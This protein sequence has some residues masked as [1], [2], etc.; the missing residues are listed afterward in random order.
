MSISC[1]ACCAVCVTP[2]ICTST[3]AARINSRSRETAV[4][5]VIRRGDRGRLVLMPASGGALP[6]RL[7]RDSRLRVG[8]SVH[9]RL[10]EGQAVIAAVT[11]RSQEP[12]IGR[13]IAGTRGWY[14]VAEGDFRGR[15]YLEPN[16]HGAATT[17]TPLRSTVTGEESFGLIGRVVDV[18]APR[19]DL[20][21]ASITLLRAHGVPVEWPAG[22][23]RRSAR[24]AGPCRPEACTATAK[25]S[26][27][28]RS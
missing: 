8:D 7:T 22:G 19:D 21:V 4:D 18:I 10:V 27:T 12:V 9:A 28:F 17:A 1:G 15:V 11:A 2:A 20:H 26:P 24:P 13:A 3:A 14:V 23:R 6:V 25:T 16:G 5:G